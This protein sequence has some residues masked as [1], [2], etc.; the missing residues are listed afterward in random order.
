M[1]V[2]VGCI[3]VSGLSCTPLLPPLLDE[4]RFSFSV[5]SGGLTRWGGLAGC[6][7]TAQPR[8]C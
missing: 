7:E 3:Q 4:S 6:G 2:E 8:A 5:L 1:C